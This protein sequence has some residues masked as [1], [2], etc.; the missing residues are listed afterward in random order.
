MDFLEFAKSR[1]SVRKY[2]Q[3]DVED[4]KIEKILQA[5]AVA[6]T[7]M[8]NQPQKIYVVKSKEAL[9]KMSK[10]TACSFGA[11][12]IFICGYDTSLESFDID[13]DD[14]RGQI[15]ID[16]V[17]THMMLQATELGLGTCWVKRFDP[18]AVREAFNIPRN[19]KLSS[20][21]PCGYPADDS[22]PAPRH[23]ASREISEMVEYL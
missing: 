16:I 21:M 2:S 18:R 17:Q 15:D 12:I 22:A 19:I 3:R 7:A 10:C 8:N 9:E 14:H 23:T 6:P 20:I 13:M 5:A 1:Y 11:P 4:S